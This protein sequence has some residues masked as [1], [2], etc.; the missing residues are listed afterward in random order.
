MLCRL[1][2]E[3]GTESGFVPLMIIEIAAGDVLPTG[4][5]VNGMKRRF[6]TIIGNRQTPDSRH[7]W[8]I[9]MPAQALLPGN[10]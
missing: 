6:T 9:V 5:A 1:R 2:S 7:N 3:Q 10:V 8:P 4:S